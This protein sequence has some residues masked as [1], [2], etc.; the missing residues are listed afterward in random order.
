MVTVRS[1]VSVH[2]VQGVTVGH[3]TSA[4]ARTGC[5]VVLFDR[6]LLTAVDVRGAAPGTRELDLLAPGRLVQRADAI[7]LSG[8]SA[9]GLRAADGVVR[10][11][12]DNDR[13]FETPAGRVPIVPSAVIF[14]LSI[15]M[16][17]APEADDGF[18]ACTS[19]V[20]LDRAG[21]GLVGAGTGAT[22]GTILGQST[23][24]GFGIAQVGTDLS[25]VTALVVV[26]AFGCPPGTDA[27]DPRVVALEA[28]PRPPFGQSTSLIVVVADSPVD[29]GTLTRCCIAAHD[30]LARSIIPAH[31]LVDGDIV[32]A[33]GTHEGPVSP[34]MSMQLGFLTELAVEHAFA[35]VTRSK[36]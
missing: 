18:A 22:F 24:G 23:P 1:N 27:P 9:T 5:T 21:T 32:F 25:S 3:S 31:T 6:P 29:H 20:P 28:A 33:S 11:L 36:S 14:D 15:G 30:G 4:S 8:G 13:G 10:Y 2:D 34:E 26:N 19:A 7:L 35:T 12:I 17:V 16:P